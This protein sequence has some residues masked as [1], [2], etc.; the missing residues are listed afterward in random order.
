MKTFHLLISGKVQGVFFRATAKRVAE[1]NG[2]KGWI[3]NTPDGKVEA[4]ITGNSTSTD[5]FISWCRS[6]PE[7]AEVENVILTHLDMVKFN[8]IQSAALCSAGNGTSHAR[9]TVKLYRCG[10]KYI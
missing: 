10:Y 7:S 6:G 4:L 8:Y 3:K 2:I 9:A 5:K 1:E